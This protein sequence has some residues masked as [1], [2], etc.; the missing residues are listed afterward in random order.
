MR[1]HVI[2][3]EKTRGQSLTEYAIL[4]SVVAAV[5]IGMQLYVKRGL[6]GRIKGVV[7]TS[8]GGLLNLGITRNQMPL[9]YEPYYLAAGNTNTTTTATRHEDMLVNGIV[10]FTNINEN[11]SRDGSQV[12]GSNLGA[13]DFWTP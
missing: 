12:Q 3:H 2:L 4:L 11:T 5:F 10:S 1:R 8:D 6:Q 7:D 13:D 9:Q